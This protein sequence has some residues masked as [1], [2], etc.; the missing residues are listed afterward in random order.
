MKKSAKYL[1]PA[2][3]EHFV[4]AD[5]YPLV[6]QQQSDLCKQFAEHMLLLGMEPYVLRGPEDLF[7]ASSPPE[8]WCNNLKQAAGA[9]FCG[10]KGAAVHRD[11][12][13]L[14]VSI[15]GAF[16]KTPLV[17]AV[18]S[19]Q[20]PTGCPIRGPLLWVRTYAKLEE[21]PHLEAIPTGALQTPSGMAIHQFT[22]PARTSRATGGKI[23]RHHYCIEL[24]AVLTDSR[25]GTIQRLT[26]VLAVVRDGC[27]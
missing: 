24:G 13:R 6:A 20:A 26:E 1:R 3:R 2:G 21:A 22:P 19:L 4:W 25:D 7:D 18:A 11:P 9:V 27:V 5:F 17:Y 12:S 10:P 16:A 14:G 23:C 8:Q 15:R